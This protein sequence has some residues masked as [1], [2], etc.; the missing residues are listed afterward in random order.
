MAVLRIPAISVEYLKVPITGPS[1]VDL[2][3]LSVELAIVPD[4]QSPT[5]GDWKEGVW[6]GSSAAVLIGPGATIPL[7]RGTYDVYVRITSDQEVPVLLSGSIH[8]V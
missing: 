7:E 4:G 8:I 1:S 3:E 2:V 5:S 6:I